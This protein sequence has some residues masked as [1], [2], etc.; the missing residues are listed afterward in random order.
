MSAMEICDGKKI[1]NDL[2]I[3]GEVFTFANDTVYW[4]RKACL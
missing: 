2:E 1:V 3:N 4:N